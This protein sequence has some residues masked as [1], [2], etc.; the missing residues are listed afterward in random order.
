M[1]QKN[2]YNVIIFK[3]REKNKKNILFLIRQQNHIS[4]KLKIMTENVGKE[5]FCA[6]HLHCKWTLG[7]F[8]TK[9]R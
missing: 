5:C 1:S 7:R 3:K 9:K 6:T 2:C 8:K 4:L